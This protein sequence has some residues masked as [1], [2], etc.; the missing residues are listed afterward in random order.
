MLYSSLLAPLMGSRSTFPTRPLRADSRS[1]LRPRSMPSPERRVGLVGSV[2]GG[3]K[4]AEPVLVVARTRQGCCN[5]PPYLDGHECVGWRSVPVFSTVISTR[6]LRRRPPRIVRATGVLEPSRGRDAIA[7]K[8]AA[9][10]ASATLWRGRRTGADSARRACPSLGSRGL[11]R[12]RPARVR[13]AAGRWPRRN[14]A[15]SVDSSLTIHLERYAGSVMTTPELSR[16][17]DARRVAP[18]RVSDSSPARQSPPAR[19]LRQLAMRASAAALNT[20]R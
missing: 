20:S 2:V 3:C 16:C 8:P 1:P 10:S 4:L 12:Q 15:L 17:L 5:C 14:A 9:S 19:P 13:V 6:L 11:R 7:R 18:R